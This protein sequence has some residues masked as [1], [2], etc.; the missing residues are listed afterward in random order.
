MRKHTWFKPETDSLAAHGGA[1]D[2]PTLLTERLLITVPGKEAAPR[3][4][5]F[6]RENSAFLQPWQGPFYQREFAVDF[7]QSSL[8][9]RRQAFTADRAY[10]FAI[11]WRDS[12]LQGPLLGYCNFSEVIRGLFQACYLGY[13]LAQSSQGKGIMGEALEGAIRYMFATAKIHRIMANYMPHNKRSAAVLQRLGF[14]V[15]GAAKNY[16]YINGEWRDHV[17]TSP[18]N[19]EPVAP[20]QAL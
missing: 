18:T 13:A 10:S 5:Q 8:E 12:G 9:R 15:D 2:F 4:A 3:Y 1:M 20:P 16:L 17:L 6:C 14:S 7:W 11:F 19:P